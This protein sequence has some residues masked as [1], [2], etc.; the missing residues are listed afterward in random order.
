MRECQEMKAP[1]SFDEE[2]PEVR[3]TALDV[4]RQA[5]GLRA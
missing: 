2:K 4:R 3:V 5:N 1:G